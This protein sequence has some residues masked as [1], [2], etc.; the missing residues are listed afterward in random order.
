MNSR[1]VTGFFLGGIPWY[2]GAFIALCVQV[3]Y[4]EKP[5]YIACA[6]AVSSRNMPVDYSFTET[7]AILLLP[8]WLNGP[9]YSIIMKGLR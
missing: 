1:F 3:D 8:G 5:G 9:S 7:C 6:I 2:V 4:R